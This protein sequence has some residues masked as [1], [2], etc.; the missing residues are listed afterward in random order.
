VKKMPKPPIKPKR[1]SIKEKVKS[2]LGFYGNWFFSGKKPNITR[3]NPISK[4]NRG[5]YAKKTN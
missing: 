4:R 2:A 1:K 5:R 3:S